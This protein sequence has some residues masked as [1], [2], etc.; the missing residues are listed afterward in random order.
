[1]GLSDEKMI[2]MYSTM[3]KIRCF[4]EKVEELVGTGVIKGFAHL[5]IGQE[6]VATGVCAALRDTD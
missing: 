6:A 1:M 3:L 2:W 4:E 5:Y